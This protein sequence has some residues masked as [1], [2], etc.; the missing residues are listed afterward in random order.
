MKHI[1]LLGIVC[2]ILKT[3]FSQSQDSIRKYNLSEISISATRM[4]IKLKDMPQKVEIIDKATIQSVPADN[5][6]ELL[7][8]TTNLDII[9]YP[10]ISAVIGMRGFSPSAHARSYTLLLINGKS[11]GTTN[12]ASMNTTNIE[13]IEVV[14][15]PYSVLYGSDAMGGV[16]NIITKT[17]ESASGGNVTLAAGSF[18]SL[19]LSGDVNGTFTKKTNFSLGFSRQEQQKEYRIG[20]SNLMKLSEKEKLILDKASS[21]DVMR[22]SAFQTNNING[23]LNYNINSVWSSSAQAMYTFANDIGTPGNYWGSYGQS[24]KDIQRMNFYT[25]LTRSKAKTLFSFNPYYTKELVN[26]YSDN[27]DKGFVSFKS[28]VK[29]Y[30]FKLN[31]TIDLGKFK[32]L[33]GSD[34]DVYDYHSERFAA[35]ATETSPYAPDNKNTKA[36]VFSQLSYVSGRFSANAGGRFDYITYSI[37]KNDSIKGTGGEDSYSVFNPSAG[38]QYTVIKN[39]KLHASVGTAFSVPDAFKVAGS[40]SGYEKYQGNPELKPESSFTF[41]L[42]VNYTLP[43]QLLS[44]DLTYFQTKH[45]DKIIKYA[46]PLS[47][48]MSFK[49]ANNSD[50]KGLELLASLNFGSLF[51]NDFKLEVY[52]NSTIMLSN[53]VEESLKLNGIDTILKR[54]MQYTRNNN[55]NFGIYFDNYKGFSTRLHARYIGSRLEKD[56]F[57]KLRPGIKT[58]DYYAEGGYTAKDK[59]LKHPDFLIIDYTVSYTVQKNKRFGITISNLM[60]ENYSEKDGYNMPGRTIMASFAYSF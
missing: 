27:T 2:L 60:D 44:I 51:A 45:K 30:G 48:I 58:T 52:A 17:P 36:A 3:S 53:T 43:S 11:G 38:V 13:R 19:A 56:N 28:N 6:A 4:N 16:I 42:G 35:K 25:T 46:L 34:L 59:I 12:L 47:D 21:G 55:S 54:D 22:N 32:L 14:K 29:E 8:R 50:M 40:Y 49:N 1:F 9:Q 39:M 20:A 15:G 33:A 23:Q 31:E 57:S 37:E 7:K 18:G 5:V 26:N 24:K 10:G 41:D